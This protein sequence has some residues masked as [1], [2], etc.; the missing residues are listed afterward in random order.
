MKRYRDLLSQCIEIQRLLRQAGFSIEDGL[1]LLHHELR[2]FAEHER[3]E[4]D[5]QHAEYPM[6]LYGQEA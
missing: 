2:R 6:W 1:D 5:K 3:Q 4:E